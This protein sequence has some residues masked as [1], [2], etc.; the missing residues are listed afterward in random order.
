MRR[1]VRN[2]LVV[3]LRRGWLGTTR[4]GDV[5]GGRLRSVRG[6]GWL[7]TVVNVRLR[8]WLRGRRRLLIVSVGL[9]HHGGLRSGGRLVENWRRR[10][11]CHSVR[12]TLRHARVRDWTG[13]HA[14]NI[15]PGAGTRDR[16]R[17][18]A[19]LQVMC[20]VV[21]WHP[22]GD[23]RRGGGSVVSNMVERRLARVEV[24]GHH[25]R[26]HAVVDGHRMTSRGGRVNILILIVVV[27][28]LEIRGTFV[29]I[30]H[31]VLLRQGC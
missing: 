30:G 10:H 20:R 5:L 27:A 21:E 15:V 29:F 7:A 12:R 18:V 16:L 14:A 2:R 13:S 1:D 24:L 8:L 28:A 9:R 31:A 17:G 22:I 4:D 19:T 25:L 6:R 3:W 11:V 26:V 23:G